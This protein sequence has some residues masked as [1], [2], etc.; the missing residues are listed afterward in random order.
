MMNEGRDYRL[1]SMHWQLSLHLTAK[2]SKVSFPFGLSHSTKVASQVITLPICIQLSIQSAVIT[3]WHMINYSMFTWLSWRTSF[4]LGNEL[5]SWCCWGTRGSQRYTHPHTEIVRI[6]GPPKNEN[7]VAKARNLI[8]IASHGHSWSRSFQLLRRHAGTATLGQIK[9]WNQIQ[10]FP[11]SNLLPNVEI[12]YLNRWN[13]KQNP[14][15]CPILPKDV[16]I[17]TKSSIFDT[18]KWQVKGKEIN[19]SGSTG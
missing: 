18:S 16:D 19:S 8:Y 5:K 1:I 15:R 2:E 10:N 13:V 4:R 11:S 9:C 12:V 3:L 6:G 7:I 14:Q 17:H